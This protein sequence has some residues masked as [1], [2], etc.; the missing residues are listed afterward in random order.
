MNL[1]MCFTENIPHE[2]AYFYLKDMSPT[3]IHPPTSMSGW[4][5]VEIKHQC[6]D[7]T[8]EVPRQIVF[9]VEINE[10]SKNRFKSCTRRYS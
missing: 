3:H 1:G 4:L 7:I 9:K 5:F 2:K 10:A 6:K 8:V